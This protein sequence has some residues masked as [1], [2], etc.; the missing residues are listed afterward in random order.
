MIRTS[1]RT[2]LRLL[3]VLAAVFVAV[4]IAPAAAAA[5][6]TSPTLT[7]AVQPADQQGPDGRRWVERT[8]DPGQVVTE[9]LA[10][11]NFS[12][13]A[14]VFALKAADGYL[15]DKGRFN[16][17]PS[18]QQSAD[19]GTWIRVQQTVNVGPHQTK[20]VP[21]TITAP[22]DATPG[23]HPAGIAAAVT[24]AGGTVAVESRV[25][26]RVMLRAS[27]TVAASLAIS[28]LTARYER[29]W[30]PF[31]AGTVHLRYTATNDGNVAVAA[32]GR[33]SA[34]GPL[35]L[36]ARR[37][38]TNVEETLPGG[39]RAVEARLDGVW[40]VGRLGTRV[41]LT[42]AILG[43]DPAGAQIEPATATVTIWALPWPQLALAAVLAVLAL[44]IRSTLRRRR[45]RLAQLI[46]DA[47]DEGRA[48]AR[49]PALAGDAPQ[50]S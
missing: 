27:G 34:A 1:L 40:S 47:R 48:E 7:W 5:Q 10:V 46:A 21:F 38:S 13:G 9:H 29:S 33:T 4:P 41:D 2:P 12:D 43:G 42:P 31:S 14:V 6:P 26:F 18:N 24:S 44:A 35:G 20:V 15:T 32:T 23:D 30:N 25:G 3:A 49:T 45:R 16:M 19:G 50:T 28:G 11:R 22:R 8:L 39:S 37:T 17:L 36:V